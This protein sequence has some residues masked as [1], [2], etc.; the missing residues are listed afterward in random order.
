MVGSLRRQI[1]RCG[2]S[3]AETLR[4]LGLEPTPVPHRRWPTVLAC[5]WPLDLRWCVPLSR[6]TARMTRQPRC[7]PHRLELRAI[8]APVTLG[9]QLLTLSAWAQDSIPDCTLDN[10]CNGMYERAKS[11]ST[12][13]NYAD[14]ARLYKLA[15]QVI[16]DPRILYSVARVLHKD[17]R[18]DEARSYYQKFID[19][20]LDDPPQKQKASEYLV[21][22]PPDDK[23]TPA[24]IPWRAPSS[25]TIGPKPVPSAVKPSDSDS[26]NNRAFPMGAAALLATGGAGLLTGFIVGG[27][28][29][30]KEKQ[31]ISTDAPYDPAVFAR[32]VTLNRAAITLDVLGGAM[33]IGGVVWTSVW[34]VKRKP[35]TPTVALLNGTGGTFP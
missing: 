30:S 6:Q 2:D 28:A 23:S 7:G 19:S 11:Q 31:L 22:L 5:T 4:P 10:I 17:G 33:L 29:L 9:L 20:K 3:V 32:G 15:Y 16:P 35:A 12:Q 13:G 8:F 25:A 21:Q 1:D 26:K 24:S 27:V 34:F 14:A 18:S